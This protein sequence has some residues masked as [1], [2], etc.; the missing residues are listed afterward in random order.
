[1]AAYIALSR[2]LVELAVE[3]GRL[4]PDRAATIRIALDSVA[5]EEPG[6]P[7]PAAISNPADGPREMSASE[8]SQ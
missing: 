4:S 1:M 7:I 8:L 6:E 3:S 2:V 5:T